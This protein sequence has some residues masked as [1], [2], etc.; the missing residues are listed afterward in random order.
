MSKLLVAGYFGCGNLGDD[1]I[2]LGFT[3]G[4]TERGH[5]LT[6]L[7]GSPEETYRLHGIPSIQ[8][9][10][11]AAVKAAIAEHDALVFAGGSIFQDVTSAKS[12]LYYA[13][14]VREAK[15][16][17]KK[18]ILLGQ[19]V[20]PLNTFLGKTAT[21]FAFRHAS[22]VAVRDEES[23]KL[24]HS[25][26][27]VRPMSVTADTAFLMPEFSPEK[28]NDSSNYEVAGMKTVGLA[29]RPHGKGDEVAKLFSEIAK[30]LFA[31]GYMPMLLEMDREMDGPLLQAIEKVHGGKIASMKKI[32]SPRELQKRMI[33]M[34]AVISVRL[35]GGIIAST[36][37]VP[38]LLLS[39]DPKVAS[40]AKQ[41]N[42]PAPLSMNNL[43][44]QRVF[45]SFQAIMKD[46]EKAVNSIQNRKVALREK[47]FENINLL[48]RSL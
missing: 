32:G 28:D 2:L 22:A 35:H 45:D 12:T 48:D 18:I 43:T 1:A 14:L 31:N 27:V 47:A 38:S 17:G 36:V 6:A 46:R 9:K 26:G 34:E 5:R 44:A 24:L 40:F 33:R 16:Q 41:A 10:D 7:S 11:R 19:G 15:A 29:P 39:Y 20:G 42:L 21:R 25:I 23:S 37:G 8:R 13:D 4:A 3:E 30:L